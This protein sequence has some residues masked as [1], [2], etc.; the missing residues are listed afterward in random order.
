MKILFVA[1]YIPSQIRVRPYQL[2]RALIQR[3][4]EITLL[5]VWNSPEEQG[6]IEVLEANGVRV[7][8]QWLPAWRSLSNS[9]GAIVTG[10]SLQAAFSWHGSLAKRLA[11][12]VDELKPDVVHVEHLR[13]AN[14]G[15]YAKS[16]LA[17]TSGHNSGSSR[18]HIPIVWDSVDCISYLFEQAAQQSRSLKGRLMTRMEL[19]RTRRYEG[20][21]VHQFDQVAVTSPNDRAALENLA[22]NALSRSTQTGANHQRALFHKLN[23]VPN[24]VDLTYFS[25]AGAQR[26]VAQIVFT[27]KMSYHANV[28][29]AVHLVKDIMP[30]VWAQH[31]NAEVWIVGKDPA[32][33]VRALA[34]HMGAMEE[35]VVITGTVSDLRPYLQRATIAVAPLLYGAGIQNKVLEAMACG[36]PVVASLQAA[37]ALNAEMGRDLQVAGDSVTFAG[38]IIDL[39]D[40]PH[41]RHEMGQMGRMYVEQNHSWNVAAQQFECIYRSAIRG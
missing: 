12:L 11:S 3:G 18:I 15:L 41:C 6:D 14:Y 7:V 27:G 4:H 9:L 26:E 31:P 37:S 29:A 16:Y 25:P 36:T 13:G 32:P 40:S 30:R 35:R 33:E 2:I 22:R 5:A 10:K 24:G 20:W 28:T 34:S 21:L 8:A 1:P 19:G 38:A 23:V 39:L 17:R